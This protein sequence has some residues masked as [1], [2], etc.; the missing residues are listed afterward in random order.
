MWDAVKA[1][2]LEL[3][4]VHRHSGSD[5]ADLVAFLRLASGLEVVEHQM[6]GV[7]KINANLESSNDLTLDDIREVLRLMQ[8]EGFFSLLEKSSIPPLQEGDNFEKL[9]AVQDMSAVSGFLCV[10]RSAL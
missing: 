6:T 4:Y 10:T 2:A 3:W 1:I 8:Q 9:I 7:E 5:D